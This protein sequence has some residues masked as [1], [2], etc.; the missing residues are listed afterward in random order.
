MYI[1]LEQRLAARTPVYDHAGSLLFFASRDRARE[2]IGRGIEVIGSR[3]RIR[4]LQLCGPDPAQNSPAGPRRRPV[5]EPHTKESYWNVRGVWHID[6]IPAALCHCFSEVVRTTMKTASQTTH[7]TSSS[8]L[9]FEGGYP[10]R[11]KIT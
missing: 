1:L 11:V 2:L 7:E 10:A 6:W 8:T 3:K 4:S 5:A 9:A